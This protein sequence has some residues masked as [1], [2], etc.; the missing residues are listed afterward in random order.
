MRRAADAVEDSPEEAAALVA[1][2]VDGNCLEL[3]FQARFM[4]LK[5]SWLNALLRPAARL[6]AGQ[7]AARR[8]C[9]CV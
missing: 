9:I 8:G 1:A 7:V 3:M 6:A 4:L 5:F 2:L